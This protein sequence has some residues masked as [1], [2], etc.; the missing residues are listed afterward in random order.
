MTEPKGLGKSLKAFEGKGLEAFFSNQKVSPRENSIQTVPI[1]KITMNRQQP[2]KEFNEEALKELAES[3]RKEGVLQPLI[4]S[5]LSDG[6]YELIAGERRLRASRLAG[7]EEVPVV[8]RNADQEKMLELALVENIQREDL[9]AIEEAIGYQSL[10]DRFQ[11]TQVDIAERVGKSREHVANTLRL[12]KLPKLIQEDVASRRITSGHA[13]ALLALPTLQDQLN[14]RERI[15]RETLTVRDIEVM[16]QN[17][18]GGKKK[19][20]S[21]ASSLGLSP[22]MRALQD[23]MER[24]LGTRVQ[25]QTTNKIGRG[26]IVIDFFSFTDLDRIVKRVAS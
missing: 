7:A 12:L 17:R 22:Q 10:A 24:V 15:L 3:I 9:N 2:R 8:I 19:R 20:V 14:Y 25:L 26:K 11:L 4:V 6:R 18:Q 23:E 5:P 13:R 16:I 1:E 21:M